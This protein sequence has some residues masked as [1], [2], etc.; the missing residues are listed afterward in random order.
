MLLPDIEFHVIALPHTEAG[1]NW[2][3]KRMMANNSMFSGVVVRSVECAGNLGR[4]AVA[5][6]LRI[7]G[8]V[9]VYSYEGPEVRRSWSE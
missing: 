3:A 2:I 6:G 5:D 8:L 7:E 9:E 1:R 4:E